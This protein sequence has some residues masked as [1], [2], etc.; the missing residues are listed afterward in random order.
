MELNVRMNYIQKPKYITG[1]NFR[2]KQNL[3]MQNEV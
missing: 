1:L 3:N 2:N